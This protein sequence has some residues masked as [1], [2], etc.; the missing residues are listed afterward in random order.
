MSVCAECTSTHQW[1]VAC[2]QVRHS[3]PVIRGALPFAVA[4]LSARRSKDPSKQV[5]RANDCSARATPACHA[6]KEAVLGMLAYCSKRFGSKG[7]LQDAGDYIA[8][9][10]ETFC[11]ELRAL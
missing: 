7:C 1:T 4:F 9:R 3:V 5:R 8:G 10:C 11:L 2:L 6:T